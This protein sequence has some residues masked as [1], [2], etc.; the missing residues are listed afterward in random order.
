M[1]GTR[2]SLPIFKNDDFKNKNIQNT[3]KQI[4]D[5]VEPRILSNLI[6][7]KSFEVISL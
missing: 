3:L 2:Q 1:S 5:K 6:E 4:A 7:N